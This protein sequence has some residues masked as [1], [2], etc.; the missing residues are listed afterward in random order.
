[1]DLTVGDLVESYSL[2]LRMPMNERQSIN[3]PTDDG[4]SLEINLRA[5]KVGTK[6]FGAYMEAMERRT[7]T[8][9]TPEA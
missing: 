3:V 1:M 9:S 6:A 5:F 2:R 4:R 7:L 8:Q